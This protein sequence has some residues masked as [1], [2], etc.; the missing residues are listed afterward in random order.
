MR[1]VSWGSSESQRCHAWVKDERLPTH[2]LQ[3]IHSLVHLFECD[4]DGA[5]LPRRVLHVVGLVQ[6][7]D[8]L[9]HVQWHLV[10]IYDKRKIHN[11][12]HLA[13]SALWSVPYSEA[14]RELLDVNF[15]TQQWG[16]FNSRYLSK[17]VPFCHLAYE[18]VYEVVVYL[19]TCV[20]W[21]L[22]GSCRD[23]RWCPP[24]PSAHGCRSM[25]TPAHCTT[26]MILWHN[27][28]TLWC[29]M[30]SQHK[31]FLTVINLVTPISNLIHQGSSA[32]KCY[33]NLYWLVIAMIY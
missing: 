25:D 13:E 9:G 2:L 5:G 14:Q 7:D 3:V 29:N 22:W 17:G 19:Q 21:G 27:Y 30:F 15:K 18:W 4:G 23:R 10:E 8:L 11:L 12:M 26:E 24:P 28:T 32:I 1:K 6:D 31:Q 20:W 33:A 16:K